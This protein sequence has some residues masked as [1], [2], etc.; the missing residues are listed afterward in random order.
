MATDPNDTGTLKGDVGRRLRQVRI[1]KGMKQT[2][3]AEGAGLSQPQY[4]PFETGSRLLSVQAAIKLSRAYNISLD[5]LYEGDPSS[6]P[7]KVFQAIRD[8]DISANGSSDL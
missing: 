1:A 2:D 6:L 3:F 7:V 4:S 5:W 8:N